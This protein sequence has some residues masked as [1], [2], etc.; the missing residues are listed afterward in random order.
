MLLVLLLFILWLVRV[1][2]VYNFIVCAWKFVLPKIELDLDFWKPTIKNKG[3]FAVWVNWDFR[4]NL[5][6][7]RYGYAFSDGI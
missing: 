5:L 6:L 1:V 4:Y 2:L 7:Y 3:G